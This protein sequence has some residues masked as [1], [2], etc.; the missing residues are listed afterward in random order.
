[1]PSG[2][3]RSPR[4][5]CVPRDALVLDRCAAAGLPVVVTLAGGYAP[6][7][8]DTVDI[9]AATIATAAAAR[10]TAAAGRRPS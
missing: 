6:D 4:P 2:A 9:H 7:V 8:A 5:G 10:V 1:M 3:S